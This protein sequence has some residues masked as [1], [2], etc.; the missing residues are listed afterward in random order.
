MGSDLSLHWL[1]GETVRFAEL[2]PLIRCPQFIARSRLRGG[3]SSFFRR[4][5]EPFSQREK[6]SLDRFSE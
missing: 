2:R 4:S 6:G 5:D 1:L 3:K